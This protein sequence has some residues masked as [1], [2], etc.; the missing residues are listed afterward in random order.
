MS[1]LIVFN[2]Y[3][4]IMCVHVSFSFWKLFAMTIELI[5][6]FLILRNSQYSALRQFSCPPPCYRKICARSIR[7]NKILSQRYNKVINSNKLGKKLLLQCMYSNEV[8][9]IVKIVFIYYK[10]PMSSILLL[11]NV[12]I[13]IFWTSFDNK[14]TKRPSTSLLVTESDIETLLQLRLANN[15]VSA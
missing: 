10:L 3:F 15:K 5:Q 4:N 11:H 9:L 2:F 1:C 12:N 13:R 8:P 6:N 14:T 7:R